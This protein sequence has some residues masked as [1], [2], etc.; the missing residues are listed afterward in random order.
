MWLNNPIARI[1]YP[2]NSKLKTKNVQLDTTPILVNNRVL[3]PIRFIGETFGA[4]VDWDK[5][6]QSINIILKVKKGS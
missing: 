2:P 5:E 1:E 6:T 3:V 4:K